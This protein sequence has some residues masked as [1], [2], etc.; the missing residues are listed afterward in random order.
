MKEQMQGG[1]QVN[2][3]ARWGVPCFNSISRMKST[4][5]SLLKWRGLNSAVGPARSFPIKPLTDGFGHL[6]VAGL[7]GVLRK[8]TDE[9]R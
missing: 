2:Q 9:S 8:K 3:S 6:I 5:P 1:G 4:P 7:D